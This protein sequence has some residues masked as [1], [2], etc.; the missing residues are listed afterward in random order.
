MNLTI[1]HSFH[2]TCGSDLIGG[3]LSR[4]TTS[5][6]DLMVTGAFASIASSV[7]RTSCRSVL[8][9]AKKSRGSIANTLAKIAT[10]WVRNA[11]AQAESEDVG[12]QARLNVVC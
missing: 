8:P 3:R 7:E 9:S 4:K 11:L 10:Q 5:G 6:E 12:I 2:S 1:G